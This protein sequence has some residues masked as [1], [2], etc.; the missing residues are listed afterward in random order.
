MMGCWQVLP[1]LA[2][3]EHT[4]GPDLWRLHPWLSREVHLLLRDGLEASERQSLC[5]AL[6]TQLPPPFTNRAAT[7]SPPSTDDEDDGGSA[8][9]LTRRYRQVDS[10]YNMQWATV[11]PHSSDGYSGLIPSLN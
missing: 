2:H 8:G 4:S 5:R 6:R 11:G 1:E 3:L 7:A 9:D 10:H